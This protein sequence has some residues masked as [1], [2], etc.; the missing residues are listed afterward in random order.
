M[1]PRR[2]ARALDDGRG[3]AYVIRMGMGKDEMPEI[4]WFTPQRFQR[5]EMAAS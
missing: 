4:V 1:H 3:A 2:R 5:L